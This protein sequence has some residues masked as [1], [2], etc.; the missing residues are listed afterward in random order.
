M[1]VQLKNV[2]LSFP[3]L[4]KASSF[5]GNQEAK[6]SASFLMEKDDPQVATIGKA[7]LSVAE[8]K[9]GEKAPAIY[10]EIRAKGSLCLRDGDTKAST[11]GYEGR[12]FLNASS[13]GRPTLVDSNRAPLAEEDGK[14]YGGAIV[15]A[16]IDLWCKDNGYGKRVCAELKGVQF[17]RHGQAFGG[18][19]PAS[20]DDFEDLGE[21]VED[22]AFDLV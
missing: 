4:F 20:A 12:M 19:A 7:M 6:F 8:G 18:S 11:A 1:K 2:I 17:V 22:E 13:K 9:W 10:K 15:N 5:D 14:L 21:G 16:I 3:H